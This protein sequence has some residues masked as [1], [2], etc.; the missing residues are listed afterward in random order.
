MCAGTASELDAGHH[1][2]DRGSPGAG[3]R[4]TPFF[5]IQTRTAQPQMGGRYAGEQALMNMAA[6]AS[7]TPAAVRPRIMPVRAGPAGVPAQQLH[8][9]PDL[10][11]AGERGRGTEP[12]RRVVRAGVCRR[13]HAGHALPELYQR[14]HGEHRAFTGE[15]QQVARA[16]DRRSGNEQH[17]ALKAA[18]QPPREGSGRDHPH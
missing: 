9:L 11:R 5:R 1:R 14:G 7:E 6:V 18:R 13:H 3:V 10:G 17:A 15:Q 8:A 12:G 4:G 2:Q 16:R